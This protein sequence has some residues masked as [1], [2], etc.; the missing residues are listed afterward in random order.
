VLGQWPYLLVDF[1]EAWSHKLQQR[2]GSSSCPCR[3]LTQ[4]PCALVLP[5][6]PPAPRCYP[7]AALACDKIMPPFFLSAQPHLCF[8]HPVVLNSS[9]APV[10][11]NTKKSGRRWPCLSPQPPSPDFSQPSSSST[12]PPLRVFKYLLCSFFSCITA[13]SHFPLLLVLV[14]LGARHG[15]AADLSSCAAA[16]SS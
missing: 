2:P 15:R 10:A 11:G 1:S 5:R 14:Q 4:L 7:Y 3:P 6:V 8:L 12:A 9:S 13:C 16:L